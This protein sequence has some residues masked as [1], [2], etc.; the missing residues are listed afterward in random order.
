MTEH[1]ATDDVLSAFL[2]DELSVEDE[3]RVREQVA[4][5]PGVRRRLEALRQ[6]AA[7]V[8]A[9]VTPLPELDAARLRAAAIADAAALPP[10]RPE[11]TDL[12]QRRASRASR[13][14]RVAAAAAAV[15][16]VAVAV[17]TLRSLE[18]GSDDVA[19]ST[20]AP[21]AAAESADMAA[22]NDAG[23]STATM[24]DGADPS[25]EALPSS[26][27]LDASLP[28]PLG[29]FAS[30]NDAVAAIAAALREEPKS[31]DETTTTLHPPATAPAASAADDFNMVEEALRRER[32]CNDREL[33]EARAIAD[34]TLTGF[35]FAS[36]VS[37]EFVDA[38][39]GGEPYVVGLV[40]DSGGDRTVLFLPG[41]GCAIVDVVPLTDP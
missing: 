3:A 35:S 40:E 21:P 38:T 9:P 20:T 6:A 10:E 36:V 34:A 31:T 16:V 17:P 26:A 22:P 4:T 7:I 30:R 29:S 8:A 11:A 1:P 23:Q 2:D 5:D 28:D 15:A 13:L 18:R 33:A 19:E 14:R 41:D 37:A 32:G 24:R 27:A 39:I 25:V 12:A